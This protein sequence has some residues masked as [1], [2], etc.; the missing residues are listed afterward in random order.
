MAESSVHIISYAFPKVQIVTTAVDSKLNENFFLSPGI[1]NFGDRFYGTW[2]WCWW[3][4]LFLFLLLLLCMLI[5]IIIIIIV[6]EKKEIQNT[7]WQQCV[8]EKKT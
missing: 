1:G 7:E 5:L 4:Y 8:T 2:W 6:V 3:W